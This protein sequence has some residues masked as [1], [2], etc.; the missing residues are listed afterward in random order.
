MGSIMCVHVCLRAALELGACVS[1]RPCVC[2]CMCV[3]MC[4]CAHV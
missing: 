2:M 1:Y 3:C 4:V